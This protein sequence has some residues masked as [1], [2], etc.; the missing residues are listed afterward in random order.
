MS[1]ESFNF[2]PGYNLLDKYEVLGQ[3]GSG[4]E[5]E[6]Y[7]IKEYDTGIIRA[8]KFFYPRRNTKNLTMLAYAKKLHHLKDCQ[9]VMQY[10]TQEKIYHEGV[11]TCFLVSEYVEGE[12]LSEYI[13]KQPG[14]RLSMH[15]AL[16]LLHQLASGLDSIHKLN[17]YHGDL[18]SDNIILRRH[19]IRFEIKV[20][21]FFHWKAPKRENISDDVCNLIHVFYECLGGKARYA[22]QPPEIKGICCG[23]K[24]SLILKKFKSAGQLKNYL[25]TMEWSSPW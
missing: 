16:H 3:L 10:Y 17:E 12:K 2:E 9:M 7:Q 5:G 25:E 1:I 20:L 24:R 21:D 14:R 19:G 6:V 22:K 18:H 13:K 8:A 4:W 23:L 11:E 15:S